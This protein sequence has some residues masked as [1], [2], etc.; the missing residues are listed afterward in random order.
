MNLITYFIFFILGFCLGIYLCL[1][2]NDNVLRNLRELL[3]IKR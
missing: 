1:R 2:F 3:Q